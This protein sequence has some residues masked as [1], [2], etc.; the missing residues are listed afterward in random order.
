MKSMS[1]ELRY[2]DEALIPL[3]RGLCES[4]ALD[5]EII[6][7]GQSVDGVETIS[8][9]VYG[10][11]D[12]YESILAEQESVLEYDLTT[13][14]NGFFV[15][16]RQ[17]LGPQGLSMM[18]SLAQ[19]TVVIVPPIEFRSDQTMRMTVVGHPDDLR[20][21]S[22]SIPEGI[23][24][25]ILKIGD[26]VMTFETSISERQQDALRVAWD[27]GYFDVPR[28]NGIET[29][30]AELDCAISTASELLRRGEAHAI[31]QLLE[32]DL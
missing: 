10:S 21:V 19:D 25:E 30:A 20:A 26:G 2:S 16:L 23:S 18:D 13:D 24:I 3:H 12:A 4:P 22:D 28:R 31:S 6:L 8:S 9:F 7:G 15:Y 11:P 14:E 32:T 17:E 29:V 1:V 27:V 5:R